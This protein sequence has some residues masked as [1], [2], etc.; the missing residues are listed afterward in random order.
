MTV[1][2]IPPVI[3]SLVAVIVTA[4]GEIPV[5][6]PVVETAAFEPSDEDHRMVRPVRTA[7]LAS[8]K[9][10]VIT[11]EVPMTTVDAVEVT[12]TAATVGGFGGF[13]VPESPPHAAVV[14]T[15]ARRPRK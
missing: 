4:P 3:P 12:V 7:P 11:S 2:A 8:R 10:A 13:V 5:T 6:T 14:A 15:T 1:M 9:V